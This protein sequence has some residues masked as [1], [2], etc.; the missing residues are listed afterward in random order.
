MYTGMIYKGPNVASKISNELI[1]ILKNK[2]IKNISE[3]IGTKNW[4]WLR[5]LECLYSH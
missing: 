5:S 1:N 4:S 3:A 2:G